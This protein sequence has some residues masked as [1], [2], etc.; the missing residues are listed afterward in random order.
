MIIELS[1]VK[2]HTLSFHSVFLASNLET[3]LRST[4]FLI[5]LVFQQTN[6]AYFPL[7]SIEYT[8]FQKSTFSFSIMRE[9]HGI[10]MHNFSILLFFQKP[11][12]EGAEPV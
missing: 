1:L 9:S 8:N 3:V 2:I 5:E 7:I 12:V 6:S 10:C 4:A 11:V